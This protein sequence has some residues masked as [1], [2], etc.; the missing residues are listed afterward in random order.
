[1]SIC[2]FLGKAS[3]FPSFYF[4]FSAVL[5][6]PNGFAGTDIESLLQFLCEEGIQVRTCVNAIKAGAVNL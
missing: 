5:Q 1:M 4:S 2:S 6:R 3:Q